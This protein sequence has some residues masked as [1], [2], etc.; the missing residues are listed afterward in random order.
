[1]FSLRLIEN[2][3]TTKPFGPFT[4]HLDSGASYP[5][6]TVDHIDIPPIPTGSYKEDEYFIVYTQ[7]SIPHVIF[8][9]HINAIELSTN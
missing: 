3:I 1:M 2:Y 6:L 5:I 8:T 9:S 4:V 7:R